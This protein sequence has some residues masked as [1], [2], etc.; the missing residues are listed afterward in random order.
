MSVAWLFW[1][2]T[3]LFL[4]EPYSVLATEKPSSST[5]TAPKDSL[6]KNVPESTGHQTAQDELSSTE[7][8]KGERKPL[9][10]QAIQLTSKNFG[11]YVGDG[12]VWLI[13]FYTP[14]YVPWVVMYYG[15]RRKKCHKPLISLVFVAFPLET[16][17]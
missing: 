16:L 3:L 1:L 13:E 7:S 10:I 14:W 12:N 5:P 11:A 6:S 4:I 15:R 9:S 17:I 2:I 8:T